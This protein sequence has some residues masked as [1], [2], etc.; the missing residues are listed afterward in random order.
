M[1]S[2]TPSGL[3]SEAGRLWRR[4]NQGFSLDPHGQQSLLI[5][6]EALDRL[7]S[8]QAEIRRDGITIKTPTGHLKEHPG[9]KIEKEARS[10][11]LQAWRLVLAATAPTRQ[12]EALDENDF[13]ANELR[14]VGL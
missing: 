7:R 4:M 1:K 13:I 6:C 2:K 5:A 12:S 11:F 10:G 8:A 14:K 9:L 3:S